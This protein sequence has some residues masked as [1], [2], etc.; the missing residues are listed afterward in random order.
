MYEKYSSQF[1]VNAS[2]AKLSGSGCQDTYLL[3]CLL[4]LVA[5]KSIPG[6]ENTLITSLNIEGFS[7]HSIWSEKS[8]DFLSASV[9]SMPGINAADIQKPDTPLPNLVCYIITH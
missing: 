8:L 4:S 3:I 9:F 1:N 5:N 6:R 7:C 2:I